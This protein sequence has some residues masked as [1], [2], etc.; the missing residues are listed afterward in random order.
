M[1][2]NK[3]RKG[4]LEV[5]FERERDCWEEEEEEGKRERET[6]QEGMGVSKRKIGSWVL[7]YVCTSG[8]RSK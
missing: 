2:Q 1:Q 6:V 5:R 8:P 7:F 3:W 4:T